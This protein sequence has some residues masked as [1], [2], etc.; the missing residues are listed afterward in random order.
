MR[1]IVFSWNS[2]RL[3]DKILVFGSRMV[4]V[5]LLASYFLTSTL[6]PS[7]APDLSHAEL[8]RACLTFVLEWGFPYAA[9]VKF[10]SIHLL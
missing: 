5:V 1:N 2:G 3:E 9:V 6:D 7:S 10:D 8:N 4:L